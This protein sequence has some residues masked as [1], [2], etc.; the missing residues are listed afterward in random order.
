[1]KTINCLK[2][3]TIIMAFSICQFLNAQVGLGTPTPRGS[4]DINTP[5]T[6]NYGLVLPTNISPANMFNPQ[7]GNPVPGTIMYD[8]TQD[9][10]KLYKQSLNGGPSGWS[11]CL[12]SSASSSVSA[13]CNA[14]GNGFNGTYKK[15]T[16]MS[17]SNTFKITLTNN[18][19]SQA[20]IALAIS[21]L[22]LSGVTGVTVASVSPASSTINAGGS[23]IVT[24]TLSGN[25]TSCGTLT[26]NWQKITLNCTKITTVSPNPTF[27]C[28]GGA[29]SSAVSPSEKLNG[30]VNGQIYSGTYT[31]PYTGG[32]CQ[33][34][35]ETIESNGLT[36]SYSGGSISASGTIQYTLSGTYTGVNNGAVNFVTSGG[37]SIYLG[38]CASCKE[39]RDQVNGTPTGLYYINLNKTG[40]PDIQRVYCDMTTDGGGWT[41]L[42]VNGTSFG[43]QL[44][45]PVITGLSDNG[46]LP[47]ATVIKIANIGTQVQLRAGA[48]STSYANRITSQNGGAAI[49]ALRNSDPTNM[50]LG[51]WHRANAVSDF[52]NNTSPSPIGT[53]GWDFNSCQ[54]STTTGWPMMYHSC[55]AAAN[56]HWFMS[57]ASNRTSGGEPWASTWIR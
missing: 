13:D 25:P 18:S 1:M 16:A 46:F 55:G 29:W 53:W 32:E 45:K 49:L 37:C 52:T 50:G 21:D 12:Q 43:G 26:G 54:P 42:A 22:T 39:I 56:V 4:L 15:G 9:C 10:I 8:S 36:F 20:T 7:G 24:Y 28:A 47:R 2:T 33:L 17:A 27:T 57:S 48:A 44:Q 11:D 40:V 41:L 35:A 3:M 19:F 30:L 6:N 23:Q 38:P 14:L 34:P 5:T 51:T 31:I